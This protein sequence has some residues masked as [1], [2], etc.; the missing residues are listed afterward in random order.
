[1]AEQA[2]EYLQEQID[3]QPVTAVLVCF[4]AGLA[5][6]AGLVALS[7]Q[8]SEHDTASRWGMGTRSQ[9]EALT[10]RISDAVLQAIPAQWR[11]A[12]S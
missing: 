3:N 6:G 1:M 2:S 12:M 11:H 10:Q 9:R 7:C 5:V 8:S 4:A